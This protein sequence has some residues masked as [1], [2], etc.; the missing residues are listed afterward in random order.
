MPLI[1][2]CSLFMCHR[3][4]PFF[5]AVISHTLGENFS[6]VDDEFMMDF[7]ESEL[8]IYG[9]KWTCGSVAAC[10]WNLTMHWML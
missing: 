10:F 9:S 5:V 6:P 7:K 4:K 8:K 1:M 2:L 3:L